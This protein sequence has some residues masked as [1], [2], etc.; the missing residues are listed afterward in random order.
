MKKSTLIFGILRILFDFGMT[1]WAFIIAWAIRSH[2]DL[3]PGVQ[4]PIGY[5]PPLHEYIKF[6]LAASILLVFIFAIDGMYSFKNTYKFRQE[7]LRILFLATA[8]IMLLISYF[9]VIRDTFFSRLVLI[10]AWLLSIGMIIVGRLIV[11]VVQRWLIYHRIGV[12]KLLLI[13]EGKKVPVL[14]ERFGKNRFYQLLNNG[15]PAQTIEEL[16]T[17]NQQYG[18]D[19]IMNVSSKKNALLS[20]EVLEFCKMHHIRYRFIPDLLEVQR[21]NVEVWE[22][23]GLPIIELKTTPLDG[24]GRV[25]KRIFDFLVSGILLILLAPFFLLI[26]VIIKTDSRG[27]VFFR[28]KR[29]GYHGRQFGLIK[30][31]SMVKDAEKLKQD[32]LGKSER[33]GPL[34]KLKE[35]PRITRIGGFLRK[36]SIDELPQLVNVFIGDMSLVGPR[37]HLP[38]EVAQYQKHQRALLTIKPGISGMAQVNGRSGLDFEE[39]VGFD[40][41]YI[42]NWSLLLDIIILFKTFWVVFKRENAD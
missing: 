12:S 13:G 19:E 24:W 2:T 25:I 21:T 34:F 38:N 10:Y 35:D 26:A 33:K 17:I 30:F 37:P 11:R 7:F 18:I 16:Q 15:A 40:L 42:E 36:W 32:M 8:W 39:E 41:Y 9:F 20:E 1:A 29:V 27:P 14:A 4:L 6:V 31:R 22:E 23:E 3:I 28:Q 5:I